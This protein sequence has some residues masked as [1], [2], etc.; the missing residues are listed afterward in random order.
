MKKNMIVFAFFFTATSFCTYEFSKKYDITDFLELESDDNGN[1]SNRT[2]PNLGGQIANTSTAFDYF[3]PE[4][5]LSSV[6]NGADDDFDVSVPICSKNVNYDSPLMLA[7]FDKNYARVKKILNDEISD[8]DYQN[9]DGQTALHY[10]VLYGSYPITKFLLQAGAEV[11]CMDHLN[12]TPLHLAAQNDNV[13][14]VQLLIEYDANPMIQDNNNKVP[15]DYTQDL[16]V[17]A[18]VDF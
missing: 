5:S 8:I 1:D 17:L 10:A 18:L 3:Q 7:I 15:R 16:Q 2:I 6:V 13:R 4:D 11:D 14:I 12:R 9:K